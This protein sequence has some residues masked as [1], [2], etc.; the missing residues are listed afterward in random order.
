MD[1]NLVGAT[2][3]P[4]GAHGQ[5]WIEGQTHTEIIHMTTE[6]GAHDSLDC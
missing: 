3:Q 2:G 6:G 1:I 5:A 4:S